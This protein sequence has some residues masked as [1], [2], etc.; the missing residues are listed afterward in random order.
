[1][2]N[3]VVLILYNIS[4]NMSRFVGGLT[5]QLCLG[6]DLNPHAFR[7]EI[8]SLLCIPISP[9]RQYCHYNVFLE[10]AK[11]YS[12]WVAWMHKKIWRRASR[13]S[14]SLQPKEEH[15]LDGLIL[16]VNAR[17]EF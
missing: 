1:M 8:L 15:N 9:P 16:D 12:Y 7:R 4:Y 3:K 14:S 17:F 5:N 2:S 13:G 10:N 6:R 11:H